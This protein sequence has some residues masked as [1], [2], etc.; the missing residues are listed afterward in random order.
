MLYFCKPPQII[1]VLFISLLSVSAPAQKLTHYITDSSAADY[2][3]KATGLK[4]TNSGQILVTS[5]KKG[6]LLVLE[7]DKFNKI[8]LKPDIFGD[9]DLAG[10][11]LL[12]NGQL[13]IINSDSNKIAITNHS[14]SQLIRTFANSGDDPGQIKAAE[15]VAVSLNN[16]IYVADKKN[17][18][19]SVFNDQGLFL[20]SFGQRGDKKNKLSKPT[21]IALDADENVYVLEAG[22]KNRISIYRSNGSLLKQ[23]DTKKM[24]KQV[25]ATLD[26]S[27][28]TADLNGMLYLA[29][30][31]KN[32]IIIYDWRKESVQKN[33]GSLGQSRGQFRNIILMS[34][35]NQ[36]QLAVLDNVNKKV[37]IYQLKDQFYKL[38]EKTDRIIFSGKLDSRCKSIHAFK[39]SRFLCIKNNKKGIVE[40]SADGQETGPF[41]SD[42]KNPTTL[43]IGDQMV[44]ILEKNKLNTYTL[45]GEFIYSVGNY[46]S[47]PGAFKKPKY[48]FSAHNKVY[49]GDSGNNRIQIFA[50]DGQFIS[51]IK[52]S[53]KS[54]KKVGP[55][56]VD[57][58][59][60]LYVA[61]GEEN[62]LVKVL[63]TH[64]NLVSTIDDDEALSFKVEKIHAIDIDNQDRL[65]ALV[66]SDENKFS[67]RIY[68]EF[69]QIKQFG[70][71]SPNKS[72]V[73]F[74]EVSSLSIA[75]T[76][77]TSVFINDVE[78]KKI[79][80]FDYLE[81]PDAAFGLK[82]TANKKQVRLKWQSSKNPVISSYQVQAATAEHGPFKT[83][84]ETSELKI[85]LT[86]EQTQGM[87]W[88]RIV[89][90]SGSELLAKPSGARLN[91]FYKLL[92]LYDAGHYAEVINLADR[93][94]K[95]NSDTAD[96][97]Q[98]KAGSQLKSGLLMAAIKSY[99]QL[100]NKS[101][102]KKMALSQQVE[103]YYRLGQ[104]MQSRN[105][106]EKLL[107]IKPVEKETYLKC[108]EISLKLGDVI[109]AVTC[110]E[111]GLQI[112]TESINLRYLLGKSYLLADIDDQGLEQFQIAL[113]KDP[114]DHT[115]RLK[116]AEDLLGME[117]Y[118]EALKHFNIISKADPSSSSATIGQANCLLKLGRDDEA[119]AI[120]IKLSA[121]TETKTVAYYVL[122]K[123]AMNQQKFTEA[124]L[125][126][127]RASNL[128]PKNIDAW[129]SLAL[130][131][132]AVN[133]LPEA[134]ST[135]SKGLKTNSDAF[136]LYLL[137]GQM[138]LDQEHY[139]KAGKLFDKAVS[140]NPQSVEANKLYARSLFATRNYRSAAIYAERC[141]KLVPKDIEVLTLQADIANK[142]GEIGSAIE[143]LKTAILLQPASAELQYQLGTV[144]LHA[145]LFDASRQHLE[146][147]AATN[148]AWSAPLVSLGN[149]FS[150]RRLFDD[151][152]GFYEKAVELDPS[153]LNRSLLNS[154]FTDKKQSLE[155][156]NNAPQ[157]VLSDLNLNHVFS[158]AYKKY[159][160][161]SI[162][163]V[164]L[165]NVAGTDY[166]N[167]ELTFQ[168]KE[169]MDFPLLQKIPLLKGNE[170]Q[171]FD[172]K[173]TFNNKIL[174][175]DEDIGVQVEVKLSFLRDG[176]KDTIRL[177]QPMTIYGKNAMVWGDANMVGSFVT[178]KDDSLRDF[179]RLAINNYLPD[180]GP[181]NDKL[182]SAMT[183]FSSLTATGAKYIVDPNTPY[184]SL[185]DDQVD[186]VQFPRETLKLKSGDC[187]DLSV[188]LSAGLENLG[189][190]T[191]LVEVP[192]HLFLMF[193][194]GL[195]VED[196]N[197]ISQ[198][199]SLTVIRDD[200]VWI[201]LESTMINASF[202]E[203]WAEGAR[204]YNTAVAAN[205]L[206][207]IELKQAWKVYQPVTLRKTDFDIE[208]PD[209]LQV[210]VLV[211]TAQTQLLSKSINRL[212]LPYQSMIKNNPAD[213]I[214]RMQIAI[215]Y[216]R[217]G[218]YDDAQQAFDVLQE[219]H[220]ED[221]AVHSNQGNLY[222]LTSDYDAAVSS[223]RRAIELDQKDGGIWLNMSMA[224][225]RKGDLK[226]AAADYQKA[227]SIT[228]VLKADYSTYSKLL[229][230]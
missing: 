34:I 156:I 208:E 167:M 37:E 10:L 193:N 93:L 214:A 147:A 178:P 109:G 154:S 175:V 186:Y 68:E 114:Q 80:K 141:A 144:Y 192:G 124:I 211:K 36:G 206:G 102:Y 69:I 81:Y 184:T 181:L 16:E 57:S 6:T 121:N 29:D 5:S 108:A 86:A 23:L 148:P 59:Q 22:S 143:F 95:N 58:Y 200:K 190:Q 161:Q 13:V 119:K 4:I 71:G 123:I 26:F 224:N 62:T 172:F 216:T 112:H 221:S 79:F 139:E 42:I 166:G 99:Q 41:A 66:S 150:K 122:G 52:A 209:K 196:A 202:T 107:A 106:I 170:S 56:A 77:K 20:Y 213:R 30:D 7:N 185:R 35:N 12:D 174:E 191:A 151:A 105:I 230:Q 204:K 28:M 222:L 38:P 96:I 113:S 217:Y 127:S 98:L 50:R 78:L 14:A 159:A 43:H 149:L 226:S 173:V 135:L 199:Q 218:L 157:L 219:L 21:H 228:P 176:K 140:L 46:G 2:I 223:Y 182:V 33:F 3:K 133:K 1:F 130:A 85:S 136:Q 229:S 152:I 49:V 169:Y 195:S 76:D 31:N 138:E 207:V 146:K 91:K 227:I 115:I 188:L 25:G 215:L 128:N 27:A 162:G 61:D 125:R 94:L 72:E 118:D 74:D 64:V 203:A 210:S 164:N 9:T 88:F 132:Q 177:T 111:D 48:V 40:L 212:I 180:I 158:A 110:A 39:D 97:L 198:D 24:A 67:I 54:F 92:R 225:Y 44:A 18:R 205:N 70:T 51:E 163:S 142:R 201:P 153:E 17:N 75:S 126:L 19:I 55:L 82:V 100:E 220:P 60:Q 189:I 83:I 47:A 101:H 103:A 90:V 73:Y 116:I 8:A 89:S 104:F 120:A 63:D 134:V 183:F 84:T 187:D 197:L 179:V 155:F 194:T 87:S 145:N 11:D 171:N 165:K 129:L 131:Y 160:N 15:G 65:Y 168:I 53:K 117:R 137:G 45:E 32:K